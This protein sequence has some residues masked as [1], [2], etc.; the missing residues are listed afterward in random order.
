MTNQGLPGT[1]AGKIAQKHK[2]TFSVDGDILYC[3]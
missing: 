3:D 2:K 1:G